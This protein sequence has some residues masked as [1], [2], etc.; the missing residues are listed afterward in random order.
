MI[1]TYCLLLFHRVRS[2]TFQ[3]QITDIGEWENV[4]CS[5]DFK[6]W[7]WFMFL[8]IPPFLN[9]CEK[10]IPFKCYDQ[11]HIGLLYSFPRDSPLLIVVPF[12][13]TPVSSTV[14]S[15]Y[16]WSFPRWLQE[17]QELQILKKIKKYSKQGEWE[18]SWISC[19]FYLWI[20]T[21]KYA[22]ISEEMYQSSIGLWFQSLHKEGR[23]PF[24]KVS[25]T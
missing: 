25:M 23:M 14:D 1:Y 4:P 17:R 22:N 7:F 8:W 12:S 2:D 6:F 24:M 18:G 3:R 11:R 15:P 5:F 16:K 19:Q 13:K 21:L 20:F 10:T 9:T